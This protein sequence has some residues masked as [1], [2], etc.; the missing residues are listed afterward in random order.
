ARLTLYSHGENSWT[1]CHCRM[2]CPAA[3][4]ASSTIGFM[5]RSSTCAAAASPTGPAPM[6][7]TVFSA[8]MA[9]SYATRNTELLKPRVSRGFARVLVFRCIRAALGDKEGDQFAH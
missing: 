8:L 4:P 6:I 9:F 2:A 1:C 5:P 7:A 3:G